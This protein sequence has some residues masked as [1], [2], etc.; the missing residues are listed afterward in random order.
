MLH[1]GCFRITSR[2]SDALLS[3]F[4]KLYEG[5]DKQTAHRFLSINEI[6]LKNHIRLG[7]LLE[8]MNLGTFETTGGDDPKIFLRLNDPRRI[9]KDSHNQKY[10]N[11]ILNSVKNRH[12][13]SCQ[14]FEHFFTNYFSNEKRWN[15]IEDFFL[16]MSNDGIFEKYP[17]ETVNHVNIIDYLKRNTE[18]TERM[19]TEVRKGENTQSDLFKPKEEQYYFSDNMLT[20]G[21]QTMPIK[22]W[23]TEDP[24]A[25]HRIIVEYNLRIEKENFKILTN[26]LRLHHFNYYRDV[27]RLRLLIE[28]PGYQGLVT[29]SVPYKDCPIKFYK[30][31]KQNQKKIKMSRKETI[32]LFLAVDAEN[33]KVLLKAH[34]TLIGK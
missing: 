12:K 25:L 6:P 4:S 13:V 31:W 15:M 19:A 8:I 7:S 24:V 29:A 14:L 18:I 10:E 26:K 2:K 9:E 22:K 1:Q 21:I 3:S 16:G 17:G 32:E 27:M 30:W 28:F 11:F 33:P 5:N 23:I 20:I 34:R